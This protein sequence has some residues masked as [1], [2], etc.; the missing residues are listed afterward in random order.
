MLVLLAVGRH[1][2]RQLLGITTEDARQEGVA[3][4]AGHVG[5]VHV[6]GLV[7][8]NA[9][10][11]TDLVLPVRP[12]AGGHGRG[13]AEHVRVP[14][15]LARQ[16]H[17]LVLVVDVRQLVRLPRDFPGRDG[18]EGLHVLSLVDV[19]AQ[20]VQGFAVV[21]PE[22][23]DGR[24]SE[25]GQEPERHGQVQ[26]PLGRPG[27]APAGSRLVAVGRVLQ[28]VHKGGELV[29]G[30]VGAD[31]ECV[32][33]AAEVVLRLALIVALADRGGEAVEAAGKVVDRD[34]GRLGVQ[35]LAERGLHGERGYRQRRG[36][37][38]ARSLRDVLASDCGEG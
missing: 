29:F 9:L 36:L 6:C 18:A 31:D 23:S 32:A 22:L 38:E 10:G 14:D 13:R 5:A 3:P 7:H 28:Q 15:D 1:G 25:Q 21:R 35:D 20:P 19:A 27:P 2:R 11:P 8:R 34:V 4:D 37:A 17:D 24:G 30:P 16:R 12:A 33:G 26:V